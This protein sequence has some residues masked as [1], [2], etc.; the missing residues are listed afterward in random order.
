MYEQYFKKRYVE[1]SIN[2]AAHTTLNNEDT[3]SSSSITDEDNEA[4]PLV[5]SSKQQTFLISTKV[6]D[7][8]IQKDSTELD[9]NTLITPFN[10]YVLEVAESSSTTQDLINTDAEIYMYALTVSTNGPKKIIEAM[11][12]HSWIEFMQDDLHQFQRLNIWEL[13]PRPADRNIIRLKWIRKNKT[14]AE[15]TV[16]RNKSFLVGKGYRQEEGIDFEELLAPMARLEAVRMFIGYIAHKEYRFPSGISEGGAITTTISSPITADEKIKKKNDVKAGSMLLIALPNEHL[17]TFNQYKDAKSLFASIETRLGGNEATKKTHKTLL[18]QMYKNFSAPST[19]SLPSEWNTHVVVWRNKP[20]LDTVS[21]DDL[22]NNFKIV[23]QEDLDQIHED[24]IEDMDLKWQLALLSMRSK[25]FFY[26]IRKKITINGSDTEGFDMSKVEC[27]NCH[28]MGHFAR[29]CKGPRNQ[30]S[31]N[32]YQDSSRRTMLVE[33]TP[34]KV[35]VAIDG[36]GFQ[37]YNVVPPPATLVYN[38]GSEIESKNASED[39]LNKLKEYPDSPLV[40]DRVSD[41]KDC[42]VKSL[43]MVEKTTV[44]PTIAKVEVVRIKQQEKP[45]RKIISTRPKAVNTA[46]PSPTVVNDIRANQ[47][48]LQKVQEDQGY[49][50]SGCSRHM[51]GNMS[52]LSKFK[53]SN[54]GYVT[55]RGGA[56]YGRITATDE[57]TG[58]LKK[59]IAEIENIVDKKVKK[60]ALVVKPH[61]KTPYELFRGRTPAL[62]FMRPFGCHVTILNTLDHLGKFDEKANEGYFVGYSMNSK[63]FKIYNIRTRRVEEN[64]HIEFMENK[65]IHDEVTKKESGASND[66]NSTFENL[67]TK[68]PNDPK[69]SGLETIATYEDSK[70]EANFTNLE[71]SIH[72]SPTPTTRTHNNHLLKQMDV[73][74]AFLYAWIKEDVYECKPSWFEDTNHPDKVYKV[75]KALYGLHQ[76]PRAWYETLTK[77]LLGNRFHKGKIDQ[78]LFIKRQKGDIL[79]VQVY[80]DD[81]IFG[82]TKKE[83]CTEFERLMKDKFLISFIRELTFFLGLQVKQKEDGIF[84]SRD[85]YV[86]EVLR[87]FNFSDVNS[88]ITL[89]DIEK[90]LVKDVDGDDI[91]VHLYRSMI[92]S[93]MYLT[94]SRPNIMYAVCFWQTTTASTLDN[95]GME[96]TATIDGKVKVVTEASIRRHL[97]LKD[98]DGISNLPTSEIFKQLAFMRVKDQQSQLSPITYPQ[99]TPH[100]NV[101][102]E[103]ASTGVDVRHGGAATTITSLDAGHG[104]GNINKTSSIPYDSPLLRVY[105]R[106]RNEGRMQ[107]NELMDL[108]IKLPDKVVALETNLKQTKKVYGAAYTKL[109]MKG[110]SIDESDQDPDVSL[111][112]HDAEIQGRYDQDM[113]FNLDFDA[114]K[115]VFNA[116]KEVSTADPVS[117]AGA[118]VTT[119]SVDVSLSSPTRRVFA[120]DDITMAKTL[121]YIQRSAAKDKG[122]G[123]MIKSEPVQTKTKLQVHEVAQ[124]FIEEEWENIR[125][126]VKADEELTQRLLVGKG[127][128]TTLLETTMRRVN[129]FVPIESEVDR[130][131]PEFA[132]GSLKRFAEEELDQGSYKR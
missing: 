38:T 16:I 43:I 89:V 68:Y 107:H 35:M 29:E 11:L 40:K 121:V 39:I 54:R 106:V 96:I 34:P 124:S 117:T 129:T 79:L 100:T 21:I 17:M 50:D 62:S 87:K 48:H 49:I 37:S 61:N 74:S 93:L 9:R 6:A 7:E 109:I 45:F 111:I 51:I 99:F 110:R 114:A 81:I 126:R 123:I 86:T 46:R 104:N 2:F 113:E 13:V 59:F 53:E 95:E 8:I 70:E 115:E 119:A 131:V 97:K 118:A 4:P 56:N 22:Y 102:D 76:A 44:I 73:K 60:R 10:P 15:S 42:L 26:K 72:V 20:D 75:V 101:V 112:Q 47:G 88:A 52:Y 77:Y 120:I 90:P 30:D 32:R 71:S 83:L 36:V 130:A 103:A 27:Y 84:I 28:K 78:T 125:A 5:Y 116:E 66:L 80:V 92:G 127:T 25:R 1:V 55:F 3:P 31:K 12:D 63:A 18:K 94:T 58:I 57:T 82:S 65:P 23:E 41:N 108:V 105:T 14:N 98:S 19:K 128:S 67:N 85:K 33:E 64:L 132:A 24:D 91:D 122:K 69:M